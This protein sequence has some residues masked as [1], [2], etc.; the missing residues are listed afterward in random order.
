VGSEFILINHAVIFL[1]KTK[2]GNICVPLVLARVYGQRETKLYVICS[3]VIY[4]SATVCTAQ[5]FVRSDK[6]LSDLLF[7][8]GRPLRVK[9]PC[10][11]LPYDGASLNTRGDD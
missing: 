2:V 3:T 11:L 8:R 5:G 7:I 10:T 1:A 4:I 9:Y 6:L